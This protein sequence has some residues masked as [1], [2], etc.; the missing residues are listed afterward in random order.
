MT[1]LEENCNKLSYGIIIYC[2]C[3]Q[4]R[5]SVCIFVRF[6]RYS[7]LARI[8]VTRPAPSN[9]LCAISAA[10]AS[11]VWYCWAGLHNIRPARAFLCNPWDL[12]VKLWLKV[13]VKILAPK[14][15]L[16]PDLKCFKQLTP[17]PKKQQK[18]DIDD[19]S[20]VSTTQF[21]N[22]NQTFYFW[23]YSFLTRSIQHIFA[24]CCCGSTLNNDSVLLF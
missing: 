14:Y 6:H 24:I 18:I 19:E 4:P 1:I 20:F 15:W 17:S 12:S 9:I 5:F 13:L 21:R 7:T 2:G 16:A 23:L 11:V 3:F 22:F 10:V 8:A